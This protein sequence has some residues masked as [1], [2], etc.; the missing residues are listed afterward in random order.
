MAPRCPCALPGPCAGRLSEAQPA[1]AAQ[2]IGR[3]GTRIMAATLTWLMQAE[4]AGTGGFFA[5][6]PATDDRIQGV[7]AWPKGYDKGDIM[8]KAPETKIP[9]MFNLH[10]LRG[11][12]G[13]TVDKHMALYEGYV[14]ATNELNEYIFDLV[15]DGKVD[16]EEMPAYSELTRRLGFGQKIL[17]I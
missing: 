10:G 15:K 16:H 4:G 2:V 7:Q 1:G 12:S 9:H 11:I 13:R 6:H 14:N 3:D 8:I 5:M 17:S